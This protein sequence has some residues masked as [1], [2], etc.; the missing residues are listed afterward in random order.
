MRTRTLL[1]LSVACG[2]AILLAG[3]VQMFRI[4]GGTPSSALALGARGTAGDL[5]IVVTSYEE[6][7]TT[8][9]V[10]VT[11]SGVDDPDGI[12][13]FRLRAPN[14]VVA[15]SGGTCAVLTVAEQTCTIEF[16]ATGLEAIDRQL[17]VQRGEDS[18]VW[19]LR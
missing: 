10:G 2:L 4:A 14:T 5:V 11:L 16:P 7:G 19:N 1:L 3:G 8:A 6:T 15:A 12:D 17:V 9:V 18:V 13:V